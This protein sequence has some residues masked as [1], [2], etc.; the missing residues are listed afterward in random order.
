MGEFTTK[1]FPQPPIFSRNY[2]IYKVTFF[3]LQKYGCI[4]CLNCVTTNIFNSKNVFTQI[5]FL[6]SKTKVTPCN[7]NSPW[8]HLAQ[9]RYINASF[10]GS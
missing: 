10:E 3:R 6:E 2:C 9:A 7:K 8:I 4:C 5:L 1:I